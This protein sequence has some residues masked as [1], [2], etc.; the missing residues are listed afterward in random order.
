VEAESMHQALW[1]QQGNWFERWSVQY[2]YDQ[3]DHAVDLAHRHRELSNRLRMGMPREIPVGSAHWK[4]LQQRAESGETTSPIVVGFEGMGRGIHFDGVET[5][6]ILGLPRKPEIYLHLAG[7]VGRPGQT[8]AKVVSII[9]KRAQKV[10]DAWANQI[11][12]DVRFEPEPIRRMRS[13]PLDRPRTPAGEG[14][15]RRE[16]KELPPAVDIP[17]LPEGGDYELLP[18]RDL[19][20][21]TQDR[22]RADKDY[23]LLP[24]HVNEEFLEEFRHPKKSLEKEV[25]RESQRRQRLRLPRSIHEM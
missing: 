8:G 22:E 23:E 9:P 3:K 4:M 10:L 12:P 13:A 19:A 21:E 1:G 7:R 16:K 18:D 5:V 14:R 15:K 11:G 17:L 25:M 24:A 20:T 6:Y 2:T